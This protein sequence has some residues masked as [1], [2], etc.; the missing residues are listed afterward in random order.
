MNL[1]PH[2]VV[3]ASAGS[4]KTYRL[5]SR[6]LQLLLAGGSPD[7]IVATTFTRKAAGEILGRVLSRLADAASDEKARQELAE[8]LETPALTQAHCVE[9]LSRLVRRLHRLSIATIDSFFSRIAGCFRHEL[10]LPLEPIMVDEGG[11]LAT[12]MRQQAIEAMLADDDLVTLIDLLRRL[13]HDE[14]DA[15]VMGAIDRIVRELHEVYRQAQ[16][17]ALWTKL[18]AE[19]L[20]DAATL[21]MLAEQHAALGDQLPTTKTGS[22]RSH[23]LRAWERDVDLLREGH[24]ED[25]CCNG[26]GS[27]INAGETSFDRT[28]ISAAWLEVYEPLVQHGRAVLIDALARQTHATW[29]LLRRFELHYNRLRQ[30]HGVL[31]YADVTHRLARDLPTLGD[32]VLLDMYYR[33][34]GRVQHLLLDEFQDTS[35]DQWA[36]LSPI[37]DEIA[38]HGDGSRTFFCVGDAKQAI[39]RWRGGCAELFDLVEEQFLGES[40]SGEQSST[41]WRSSQ[42]VLDVVNRVFSHVAES[43]ACEDHADAAARFQSLYREHTAAKAQ[44]GHVLLMSSPRIEDESA[45]PE[46]D[47]EAG[48]DD[49]TP[50]PTSGH[51]A[52]VARHVAS[53]HEA[54]P[55]ASIGI[56][57]GRNS[58]AHELLHEMRLL[59]LEVSGEGGN[60][61]TDTPAIGAICSALRLAEHPGD[62]VAAFHVLNSPL[63]QWVGLTGTG[64]RSTV[65]VARQLRRRLLDEGLPAVIA[66]WVGKLA[67]DVDAR[68]LERLRQLVELAEDYRALEPLRPARF[69]EHIAGTSV[70]TLSEAR[71]RVM[72]VHRAKGLEFD[73]VVLP[74]LERQLTIRPPAMV[75]RESPTGPITGVYRTGNSGLRS[76]DPTLK[77]LYKQLCDDE[78]YEDLCLLYV[79]MTRARH[80]LHMIV[81]PLKPL[82]GGEPGRIGWNNFTAAAILRRALGPDDPDFDGEQVL[83]ERGTA[84]WYGKPAIPATASTPIQGPTSPAKLMLRLRK[85]DGSGGKRTWRHVTPSA[86]EQDATVRGED[87]LRTERHVGLERGSLLHLWFSQLTFLGGDE[88]VPDDAALLDVARQ[89]M[90]MLDTES[91][92]RHLAT[93]KAALT[94]P[95]IRAAL[96]KPIVPGGERIEL[97]RERPFAVR[98]GAELITGMFDRVVVR[99]AGENV[100]QATL[101]DYKTDTIQDDLPARIERYRP[102]IQAYRRVLA[103]MLDLPT[104]QI[105]ARLLFIAS[106]VSIDIEP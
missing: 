82:K 79:A 18:K 73:V 48:R 16:D 40:G 46:M 75:E 32:D 14:A 39:Y 94:Q 4:G 89:A 78:A 56:L 84:T 9:L 25:I 19:G 70:E 67:P 20:L 85:V 33:L 22:P 47:G 86:M 96:A 69:A 43:P 31:L 26:I 51:L 62:S 66:D 102:Q 29:D 27:K 49:A 15:S 41:S 64:S 38:S 95:G 104:A 37:A 83:Y 42:V 60:P 76:L 81:K 59:G 21:R 34:D 61:L 63:G 8:A 44:P 106:D 28:E 10:R 68:S 74:E 87:L 57:V 55:T 91:I 35:L 5:T 13:H 24:P 17:E 3:R 99:W 93:F 53:L 23:W 90:P 98:R 72:T 54:M 100:Q 6:Y 77:A 45:G 88:P 11:A 101:L 80:A 71:L 58:T 36:V 1:Q 52:Y 65:V 105:E 30:M 7:S 12:E 92:A 50:A 103:T 2:E 97:W